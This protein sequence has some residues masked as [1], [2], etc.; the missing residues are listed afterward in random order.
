MKN[1]NF[2]FVFHISTHLEDPLPK[3]LHA[4]PDPLAICQLLRL[5]KLGSFRLQLEQLPGFENIFRSD[6]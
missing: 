1:E 5:S 3:D 6:L 2:W 4:D